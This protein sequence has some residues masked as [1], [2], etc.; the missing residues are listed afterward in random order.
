MDFTLYNQ[1]DVAATARFELSANPSF[2]LSCPRRVTLEPKAGVC[3]SLSESLS[4][5]L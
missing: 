3:E 4:E 1:G 5:S 2:S